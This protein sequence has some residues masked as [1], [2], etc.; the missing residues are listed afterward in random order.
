M[1]GTSE[2]V[3]VL[4]VGRDSNPK[5]KDRPNRQVFGWYSK[6]GERMLVLLKLL[7]KEKADITCWGTNAIKC[8]SAKNEF[9]TNFQRCESHLIEE[10]NVINPKVIILFGSTLAKVLLN[11]SLVH[12]FEGTLG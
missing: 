8:D 1:C 4:F 3:D 11:M 7:Q 9:K 12:G 5:L 6:T 10:I 2:Q